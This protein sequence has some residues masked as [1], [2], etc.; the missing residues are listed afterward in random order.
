MMAHAS[1]RFGCKQIATRRLEELHDRRVF[2][3]RRVGEVDDDLS[4]G[5]RF[6]QPFARQRVDPR[7]R[8]CRQHFLAALAKNRHELGSDESGATYHYDLHVLSPEFASKDVFGSSSDC[9]PYQGS[10]TGPLTVMSS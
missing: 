1:N 7:I 6:G 3:R 9:A 4:P 5:Q 10:S 8:R 2:E